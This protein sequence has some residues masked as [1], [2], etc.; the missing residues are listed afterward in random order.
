MKPWCRYTER[1]NTALPGHVVLGTKNWL[2]WI[3][4]AMAR[5]EAAGA[6]IREAAGIL[7][8]PQLK[9]PSD[10]FG[11]PKFSV[12]FVSAAATFSETENVAES[13]EWKDCIRKLEPLSLPENSDRI[14]VLSW[15]YPYYMDI[16]AKMTVT[17]IKRRTETT[18]EELRF[19]PS[20]TNPLENSADTVQNKFPPP[21]FLYA[22]EIQTGGAAFGTLMHDVMQKL[23]LDGPLDA[24]DIESQLDAFV[25]DGTLTEEERHIVRVPPIA[26]FFASPIGRRMKNAKHCWREQPFSLL[27]PA[28]EMDARASA[29]D[30]IFVQG[31]IDVF[32]QDADGRLVLL[33]YK[34]DRNTTPDLIRKRYRTQLDLYARA[35]R[36]ITGRAVDG[37]YIYRLS[38]GDTIVL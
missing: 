16:S 26:K 9:Y 10:S 4:T 35:I 1:M 19:M 7:E 38:D 31:I 3:G 21:D 36:T 14:D 33:D 28:A 32:F 20:R 18:E 23:R 22:E 30:E 13:D 15:K 5:D 17:E 34:T 2:D 11:T 37:T 25:T 27:V 6:A 8:V 12:Q 24:V 29:Q